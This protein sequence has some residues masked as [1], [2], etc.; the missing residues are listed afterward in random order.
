MSWFK[1]ILESIKGNE[2]FSDIKS[3]TIRDVINGNIFTKKFFQKQYGLLIMLAIL[4]FMYVDNRYYC[5]TQLAQV[6]ELKKKIKDVKYESL[7]I[8]AQLMG[9]SKQSN[10]EKM[11]IDRGIDLK[12]S[13]RPPITIEK[14]KEN[15]Q[16]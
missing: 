8:S 3:S 16:E 11:I 12:Q 2:D 6:I 5:E 9:I 1:N 14:P 4:A 13:V 10:I 15:K 7:T